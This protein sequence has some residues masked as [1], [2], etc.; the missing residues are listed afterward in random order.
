MSAESDLK[1]IQALCVVEDCNGFGYNPHGSGGLVLARIF[2]PRDDDGAP[3]PR[4]A[5]LAA[6]IA[7]A[8]GADS[9]RIESSYAGYILCIAWKDFRLARQVIQATLDAG[10]GLRTQNAL[11]ARFDAGARYSRV[12]EEERAMRG[13]VGGH[14]VNEDNPVG[15]TSIDD[16]LRLSDNAIWLS[17]QRMYRDMNRYRHSCLWESP[18]GKRFARRL[19]EVFRMFQPNDG[20]GNAGRPPCRMEHLKCVAR[21]LCVHLGGVCDCDPVRAC[22]CD[23]CIE[24]DPLNILS[25][26]SIVTEEPVSPETR[27]ASTSEEKEPAVVQE[28]A[29]EKKVVDLTDEDEDESED[30]AKQPAKRARTSPPPPP[31]QVDEPQECVVCRERHADTLALPCEHAVACTECSQRIGRTDGFNRNHCVVCREKLEAV[32]YENGPIMPIS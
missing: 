19:D 25:G 6:E 7:S 30:D 18:Q 12:A 32:V 13:I 31:S 28:K 22:D 17:L 15:T 27:P 21:H 4:D 8:S 11:R 29:D 16:F 26:F 23:P 3:H 1:R 10:L 2:A 24:G 20:M 5:A 14:D 9:V